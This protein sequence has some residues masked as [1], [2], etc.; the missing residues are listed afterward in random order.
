MTA[1]NEN[2]EEDSKV[3]RAF[4]EMTRQRVSEQKG[5]S[6]A[7]D[8][9]LKPYDYQVDYL[10]KMIRL[11]E[12]YGQSD[13]VYRALIAN[14][15]ET[16]EV[17]ELDE[18]L[19]PIIEST[20]NDIF[21]RKL[22][23]DA[24]LIN[25]DLHVGKFILKGIMIID[26]MAQK[27]KI[28]DW[29]LMTSAVHRDTGAG[30]LIV[31]A[32]IEDVKTDYKDKLINDT[33]REIHDRIRTMACNVVDMVENNDAD[34]DFTKIVPTV[35]QQEKREKKNKLRLPTKIYIR[36]RKHFQII[37]DEFNKAEEEEK[38]HRWV[39]HRFKVMGYWRH[40]RNEK[41]SEKVR[42]NPKWIKPFWK[43]Q[44]IVIRK[45]RKVMP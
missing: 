35:K 30:I 12:I 42:S 45:V 23:F 36:P 5:Y 38:E 3:S 18:S 11:P 19:I 9:R 20:K 26:R 6:V 10:R 32:L 7:L 43:G 34:I 1:E 15:L 8:K 44:G 14:L 33:I 4:S 39:T 37:L 21:Y 29:I 27:E 28:E 25:T 41:Y 2:E 17:V 31:T 16:C 40:Y 24:V 22:F 13:I